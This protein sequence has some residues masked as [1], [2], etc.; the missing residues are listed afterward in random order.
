[1]LFNLEKDSGELR[2]I[3]AEHQ[4]V[5]ARMQAEFRKLWDTLP[6]LEREFSEVVIDEKAVLKL[7]EGISPKSLMAGDRFT[8]NRD[9]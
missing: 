3:I 9:T 5:A 4:D 1:M 2:N 8:T 7:R 6:R